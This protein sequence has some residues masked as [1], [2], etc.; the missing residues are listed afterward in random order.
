MKMKMKNQP[1]MMMK[2]RHDLLELVERKRQKSTRRQMPSGP[3]KRWQLR[4]NV[5]SSFA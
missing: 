1:Q 3:S 2:L 4:Q 5:Y